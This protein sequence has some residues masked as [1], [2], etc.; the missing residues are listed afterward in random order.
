MHASL[1]AF[2]PVSVN[3]KEKLPNHRALTSAFRSYDNRAILF[4]EDL[5]GLALYRH[6]T[7]TQLGADD[8][9]KPVWDTLKQ[10]AHANGNQIRFRVAGLFDLATEG[11]G[12]FDLRYSFPAHF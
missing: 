3:A 7:R 10:L 11:L 12:V 4:T 6:K 9:S 2:Q 8:L 5:Y 1:C